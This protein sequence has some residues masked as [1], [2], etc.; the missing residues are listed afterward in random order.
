MDEELKIN[1]FKDIVGPTQGVDKLVTESITGYTDE[2]YKYVK[3][4]LDKY[5]AEDQKD[6]EYALELKNLYY[7]IEVT[8]IESVDNSRRLGEELQKYY[9][10]RPS[11]MDYIFKRD[12]DLN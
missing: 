7:L 6:K 12:P 3:R 10:A 5:V 8:F 2:V 11:Q 9:S 1:K 4:L